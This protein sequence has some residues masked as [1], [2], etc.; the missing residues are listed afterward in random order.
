MR[1]LIGFL[2][3]L[4]TPVTAQTTYH[5]APGGSDANPGMAGAPWATLQHA[6]DMADTPGDT[7]K[8]ANGEYTGFNSQHDGI[9]FWADGD[10]VVVNVAGSYSGT[11]N[12]N[13]ENNNDIVVAGFVVRD[14]PRAGIRV[15]DAER[16]TI[17]DNTVG[18]NGKWGIFSGF[19]RDIR[20]IDNVTFGSVDEHGIYL[21][22]SDG[23]ADNLTV[24]GNVSYGNAVN[25]IQFNGDCYAGGDGTLEGGLIEGNTVY[26]NGTKGLS[27][28]SAPGVRIQNNLIYENRRGPAGAAG[29]HLVDEPGCGKPTTDAIVVNNTIVEP[30]MAGIRINDGATRNVVFNNL[31]V[32]G[33]PIADEEGGNRVDGASYIMA[34]AT[35]GLFVDADGFDFRLLDDA[36]AVDAGVSTYQSISAP[37]LDFAGWPRVAGGAPDAGAYEFG[38]AGSVGIE[39]PAPAAKMQIFPNPFTSSATLRMTLASSEFVDAGLYDLLGRRVVNLFAGPGMGTPQEVRLD[40]S[41]LS[42]GIYFVRIQGHSI[43]SVFPL[44]RSK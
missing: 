25:G 15:V 16:V 32:S 43:V 44:V 37:S 18:P 28:I 10:N 19:A 22:N 41:M 34:S 7:V 27:I 2:L 3:L 17:R 30:R 36:S 26:D 14:A 8:V 13:I 40:G 31:I 39:Q 38:G 9:V 24:V 29:I 35:N 42:A 12:I 4:A 1:L 21:S 6:A 23:P 5:V 20:V 11:D 33:N